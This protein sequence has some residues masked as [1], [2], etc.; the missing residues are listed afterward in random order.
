MGEMSALLWVGLGAVLAMLRN[1]PGVILSWLLGK[2]TV[3]LEIRERDE[4]YRWFDLWLSRHPSMANMRRF[5][6]VSHTTRDDE[7][8][9]FRLVPAPG[10]H[11]M[12]FRGRR[13]IVTKVRE[14]GG[15]LMPTTIE[16][17]TVRFLTRDISYAKE[18]MRRAR[19]FAMRPQEGYI[20]V[21]VPRWGSWKRAGTI[22]SRDPSTLVIPNATRV[23]DDITRFFEVESEYLKKGIP[24][25]RGYL[26]YGPP[27]N[28][29]SS[30]V[31]SVGGI[32][33]L[34]IYLL[35]LKDRNLNDIALQW[36]LAEIP[37]K[38]LLVLE[39]VDQVLEHVPS[40]K[41]DLANGESVADENNGITLSGL[42]NALDG[43]ICSDSGRLTFMTTNF[44]ERLPANLVRPGRVD[45]QV[46]FPNVGSDTLEEM[47]EL[48]FPGEEYTR[49]SLFISRAG[50]SFAEV[51]GIL[52]TAKSASE[53]IE[54]IDAHIVG[55]KH[56]HV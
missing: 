51:Q 28:G 10:V 41:S 1:V 29:K 22:R 42:L 56:G 24:Y 35:D 12:K 11:M 50:L 37:R 45:Q 40:P 44:R 4:A 20:D 39:D 30:F 38:S 23:V 15:G 43:I 31:R 3:S 27:G 17:I 18:L 52:M 49:W 5:S 14:Q 7:R 21:Y 47:A 13:A 2:L 33:G 8:F 32:F 9:G 46:E 34:D 26:L 6:V 53:A 36:L 48:Y 55:R 16:T 54:T 25:Q 19:D